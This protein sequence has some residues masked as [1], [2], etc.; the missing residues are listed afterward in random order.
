MIIQRLVIVY[1]DRKKEVECMVVHGIRYPWVD[2]ESILQEECYNNF[3]TRPIDNVAKLH[4]NG[5]NAWSQFL[6]MYTN[7]TIHL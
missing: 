1:N 3:Y 4:T 5:N 6:S 2:G 7:G